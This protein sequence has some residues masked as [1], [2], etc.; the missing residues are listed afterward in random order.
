[1]RNSDKTISA[2]S[3]GIVISYGDRNK[4]QFVNYQSTSKEVEKIQL[5]GSHRRE[6]IFYFT[7]TQK[8]LFQ[9]VVYGLSAYTKEEITSMSK[10]KKH[11]VIVSYTKAQ[12]IL[13]RWKQE[14][15]NETIDTL[16]LRMFPKSKTAKQ[17]VSEKGYDDNLE[18]TISFKDLGISKKQVVNK[19]IEFGLLP[20]NFFNLV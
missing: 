15:V 11:Q 20:E 3:K 1:M 13:N 18:C 4:H 7:P 6:P 17:M 19:L 14:I 8:D 2:N 16:F 5:Y 9:K 12:R 10:Y